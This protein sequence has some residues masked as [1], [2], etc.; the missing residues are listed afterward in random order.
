[1][2]PTTDRPPVPAGVLIWTSVDRFDE[3]AAFYEHVLGLEATS[4]R[5]GHTG[6]ALGDLKLT[7]GVHDQV[8]GPANDPLRIMVN[9]SVLDIH[10]SVAALAGRGAH[11][12]RQPE[13]ESWGGWIATLEDPDGNILQL[14]QLP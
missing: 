1:M 14:L 9:F 6:F 12:L 3:M 4:R 11:F 2:P 13:R 7:V 10:A 5:P 8:E